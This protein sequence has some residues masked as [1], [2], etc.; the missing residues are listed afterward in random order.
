MRDLRRGVLGRAAPALNPIQLGLPSALLLGL[1][2]LALLTGELA[3]TDTLTVLMYHCL[4]AITALHNVNTCP[5]LL[6]R[7][8]WA[9][10]SRP[11][12]VAPVPRSVTLARR[13]RE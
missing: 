1:F 6:A 2:L 10:Y 3:V 4:M 13:L 11:M 5:F 12:T 7:L 8:P 9:S